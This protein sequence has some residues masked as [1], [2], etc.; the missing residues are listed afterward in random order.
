MSYVVMVNY[1]NGTQGITSDDFSEEYSGI[2][3]NIRECAQMELKEARK[4][5]A[6]N[7]FVNYCYIEEKGVDHGK[8]N[9]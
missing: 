4:E 8:E 1:W 3:H 5:T 6:T 7:L 9:L 2:R